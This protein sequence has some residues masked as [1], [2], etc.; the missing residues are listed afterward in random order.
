MGKKQKAERA[1]AHRAA[2]ADDVTQLVMQAADLHDVL[3]THT[4]GAGAA[5]SA[6][7]A[8][9]IMDLTEQVL[10]ADSDVRLADEAVGDWYRQRA[11]E[12]AALA[13]ARK[14]APRRRAELE[15]RLKAVVLSRPPELRAEIHAAGLARIQAVVEVR[16][17][18]D[19][20][21]LNGE[22]A[23]RVTARRAAQLKLR[24]LSDAL[25]R[26]IVLATDDLRMVEAAAFEARM[27]AEADATAR[28][29]AEAARNKAV[30]EAKLHAVDTAG[31]ARWQHAP[32]TGEDR[33]K[34]V[35]AALDE[36][37]A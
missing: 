11:E 30:A 4:S 1:A 14:A 29:K 15:K 20:A 7:H 21:Q 22:F 13:A 37:F 34:M 12:E 3:R 16:D 18:R 24:E 10:N 36:V 2:R 25:H 31:S 23:R 17:T 19:H 28:A 6:K 9:E 8:A 32:A 35:A 33:R 27:R 26:V 5:L